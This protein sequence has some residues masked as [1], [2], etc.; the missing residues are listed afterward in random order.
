MKDTLV[1]ACG[2]TTPHADRRG[3]VADAALTGAEVD[4]AIARTD[5]R[6]HQTRLVEQARPPR[7]F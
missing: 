7:M 2:I 4:P 1:A 5:A 3:I 6:A